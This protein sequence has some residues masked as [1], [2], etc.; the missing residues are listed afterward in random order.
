MITLRAADLDH[1]DGVWFAPD[2]DDNRERL[3]PERA[4]V[5]LTPM[6]AREFQAHQQSQVISSK[7][8][9]KDV[10]AYLERREFAVRLKCLD[11]RVKA[12]RNWHVADKAGTREL[13]TWAELRDAL[14]NST[15]AA[16]ISVIHEIFAALTE[17]SSLEDGIIRESI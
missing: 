13:R 7:K 12:I 8:R 10:G 5:L 9:V 6:S 17:H 3:E 16:H 15:E 1:P 2:I 4:A 11:A 14:L